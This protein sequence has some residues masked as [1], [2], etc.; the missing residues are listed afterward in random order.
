M[1]KEIIKAFSDKME[2][3]GPIDPTQHQDDTILVLGLQTTLPHECLHPNGHF[4]NLMACALSGQLA[5]VKALTKCESNIRNV[6]YYI[7]YLHETT[8]HGYVDVSEIEE[9]KDQIISVTF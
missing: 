7:D 1:L 8:L 2:E 6:L 4:L 3:N 5:A 9:L